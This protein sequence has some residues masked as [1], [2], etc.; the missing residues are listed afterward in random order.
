MLP[1]LTQMTL[2][3][4]SGS[5]LGRPT[6]YSAWLKQ[7]NRRGFT[8][9]RHGNAADAQACGLVCW[10]LSRPLRPQFWR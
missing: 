7:N 3:T 9:M 5:I 1:S 10:C 8:P 2:S 6:G 4:T